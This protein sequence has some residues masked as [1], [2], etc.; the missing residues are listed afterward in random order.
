MRAVSGASAVTS[1]SPN[2]SGDHFDVV[3]GTDQG[4]RVTIVLFTD[5]VDIRATSGFGRMARSKVEATWRSR[6]VGMSRCY[7]HPTGA[8]DQK[9]TFR[10]TWPFVEGLF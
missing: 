4:L 5:E 10:A 3:A 9:S 6:A 8:P 1:T 2:P 7:A